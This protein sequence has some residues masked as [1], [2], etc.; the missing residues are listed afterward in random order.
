MLV[1]KINRQVWRNPIRCAGTCIDV[2]G[3]ST[4]CR[5]MP[6]MC[7]YDVSTTELTTVE[8]LQSSLPG[9]FSPGQMW[10]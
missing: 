10:R 1:S 4:T 3:Q 9:E 8:L 2:L 5:G 6:V 7:S